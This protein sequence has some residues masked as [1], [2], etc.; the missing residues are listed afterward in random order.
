MVKLFEVT[1]YLILL[2]GRDVT[3]FPIMSSPQNH[4]LLNAS[5][6]MNYYIKSKG[7]GLKRCSKTIHL[8]LD[9]MS[10]LLPEVL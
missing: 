6:F 7:L 3:L 9:I 8:K 1:V 10:P 4:S 5:Y 2:S